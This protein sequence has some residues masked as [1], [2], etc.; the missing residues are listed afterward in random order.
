MAGAEV[1]EVVETVEEIVDTVIRVNVVKSFFSQKSTQIGIVAL[2]AVGLGVATGVKVAER[3]LQAKYD[4]RLEVEIE[5]SREILIR[6]NLPADSD[7]DPEE[8]LAGIEAEVTEAEVRTDGVEKSVNMAVDYTAMYTGQDPNPEGEHNEFLQ[9]PPAPEAEVTEDTVVVTKSLFVEEEVTAF[10]KSDHDNATQALKE[11][12]LPYA[13]SDDDFNED[14]EFEQITITWF[15][16]DGVLVDELEQLID[17]PEGLVGLSNMDRFGYLSNDKN[18]VYIRN[19]DKKI[20]FEVVKSEG[21]YAQEVL[22]LEHSD[23]TFQR[24]QRRSRLGDDG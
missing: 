22:G 12:G 21:N 18:I 4:E 15:D 3:R 19:T 9:S 10:E 16:G 17:D 6:Q 5:K 7:P 14:E 23:E 2:V 20:D 11:A 13:I 8:V 24:R 1:V